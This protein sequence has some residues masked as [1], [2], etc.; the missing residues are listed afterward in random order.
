LAALPTQFDVARN[1]IDGGIS[2]CVFGASGAGC[3][4]PALG[5]AVAAQ[6]RSRG[7]QALLSTQAGGW[8][9]GIGGGYDRRRFLAPELAGLFSVNGA[10]DE[11]YYLTMTV[12]RALDRRSDISFNGYVNYFDNGL[13]GA[14]DVLSAGATAAYT[15]EIFRNLQ[16]QA[17]VGVNAFDQDGVNNAL[18]GSALLGLRYSF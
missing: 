5:A 8:S 1:P 6:Y 17:A 14:P 16:G 10:V 4:N 2:S 12:G 3:L 11:N 15:R 9:I 18:I 13:P 7:I